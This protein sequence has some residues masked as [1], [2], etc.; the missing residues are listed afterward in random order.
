MSFEVLDWINDPGTSG[1]SGDDRF[2]HDGAAGRAW[3]VDGATDATDLKPFPGESGAAWLAETF[4]GTLLNAAPQGG[5][6]VKA[7]FGRVLKAVAAEAK[8][9]T[10]IPLE[11]LPGE[12]LPVASSMWVRRDGKS[13]EF[14][15][16]GDCYA[17]AEEGRGRARLIGTEEKAD[18]ETRG[19]ARM[20]A[21]SPE[22]R[23]ALLQAQRREANKPERGLVSL[24]PAAAN[25]MATER[26][27]LPEGALILLMTD[28]FY[29][30]VEPYRL[31][32]PRSLLARVVKDGLLP[33]LAALRAHEARPHGQRL[34]A[35]DDAAA[36]LI[37]L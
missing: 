2:G 23:W 15:W 4:S 17:I 30:F 14:V 36:L 11:K 8:R 9:Q 25:H 7:Y 5:E 35:R 6:G 29:R 10:K 16:S 27:T 37:R 21:M 12:A 31:E 1:K 34:K 19:A 20:L 32:T 18:E 3:V 24:D 28:G 22:E 13:C 33:A 26:L